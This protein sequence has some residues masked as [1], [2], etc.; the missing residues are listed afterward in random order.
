MCHGM[1]A[2]PYGLPIPEEV[3]NQFPIEVQAAWT[4]FDKWW[5]SA[6]RNEDGLVKKSDMPEPV[7]QAMSLILE[8]PIPGADGATGADSCYMIGVQGSMVD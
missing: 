2:P 5:K 4:A 6:P 3:H 1:Y 8:A 7:S